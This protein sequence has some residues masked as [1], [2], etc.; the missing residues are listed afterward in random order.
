MLHALIQ[1]GV[2]DTDRRGEGEGEG[3]EEEGEGVEGGRGGKNQSHKQFRTSQRNSRL[4]EKEEQQVRFLIHPNSRESTHIDAEKEFGGQRQILPTHA[5]KLTRL[6]SR[7]SI[8]LVHSMI[9]THPPLVV[10][11]FTRGDVLA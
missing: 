10:M 9:C 7:I 1:I 8:L 11:Y 5:N 2:L 4:A 3:G 6:H